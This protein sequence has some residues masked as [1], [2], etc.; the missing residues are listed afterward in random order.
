MPN[1]SNTPPTE[2]LTSWHRLIRAPERGGLT[3]V[4]LSDDLVGC[5]VH[6][7]RGRTRACE[8]PACEWCADG[9]TPRWTGY[10]SILGIQSG[11]IDILEVTAAAAAP[12]IRARS[13]RGSLRGLRVDV[14]RRNN[15]HNGRIILTVSVH[16]D[17][18]DSL[19]PPCDVIAFLTKLWSAAPKKHEDATHQTTPATRAA[20]RAGRSPNGRATELAAQI[21]LLPPDAKV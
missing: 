14:S 18:Y 6:Y 1:W 5:P 12:L 2:D 11:R 13:T 3:A 10:L 19:P 8:R 4:I 21:G 15:R 20:A 17:D 16:T 9:L 7:A